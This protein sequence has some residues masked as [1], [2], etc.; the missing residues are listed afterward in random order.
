MN[1]QRIVR[2]YV[3]RLNN[4]DLYGLWESAK[5]DISYE[6]IIVTYL[7]ECEIEE[8]KERRM[9]EI[10]KALRELGVRGIVTTK[11]V[12]FDRFSVYVDG[13]YFG[14]WDTTRKTFVD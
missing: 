5:D 7:I 14:I 12:D 2:Q 8:R 9:K 1:G 11:D 6:A 4:E 13:E 3:E 10:M